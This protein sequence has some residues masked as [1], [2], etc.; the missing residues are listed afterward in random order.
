LP[1]CPNSPS[2]QSV[3]EQN[4]D[5]ALS[6]GRRPFTDDFEKQPG[7]A[8]AF[9]LRSPHA[10]ANIRNIHAFTAAGKAVA[11]GVLAVLTGADAGERRRLGDIPC[12]SSGDQL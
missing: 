3:S 6:A 9:V 1:T 2:W 8:H 11:P 5:A 10:N 4:K 7:A 12:G